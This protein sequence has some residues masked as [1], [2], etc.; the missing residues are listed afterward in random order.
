M[1]AAEVNSVNYPTH[2][3]HSEFHP[4]PKEVKKWSNENET[5]KNDIS[6]VIIH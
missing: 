2:V 1:R 4:V 3:G 5:M 6:S